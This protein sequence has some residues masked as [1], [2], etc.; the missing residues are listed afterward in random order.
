MKK[1][2]NIIKTL[3]SGILPA[4]SGGLIALGVMYII[5]NVHKIAE[6]SGWP[7][8]KY[9]LLATVELILAL[10]LLYELGVIMINAKKWTKYKREISADTIDSSSEDCETSDE[11]TD[12]SPD[13]A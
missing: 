7:V 8:V 9:F 5:Q 12:T 11:S 4:M 1:L 6:T 13:R 3:I 2:F 10:M